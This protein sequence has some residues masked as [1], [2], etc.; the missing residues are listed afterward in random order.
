M[1]QWQTVEDG[2][3]PMGNECCCVARGGVV[4]RDQRPKYGKV[5]LDVILPTELYRSGAEYGS[6]DREET[7][8]WCG[9]LDKEV[10]NEEVIIR[11]V[12]AEGN[13]KRGGTEWYRDRVC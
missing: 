10:V 4:E 7:G 12:G 2:V 1:P 11:V 5:A 8:T 9:R 3:G 13:G 6:I